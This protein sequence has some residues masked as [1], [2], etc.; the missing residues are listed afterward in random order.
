MWTFNNLSVTAETT[1]LRLGL[2]VD[3]VL[4]GQDEPSL[5]VVDGHESFFVLRPLHHQTLF[6]DVAVFH[7]VFGGHHRAPDIITPQYPM[8][9]TE[10]IGHDGPHVPVSGGRRIISKISAPPKSGGRTWSGPGR[11]F[12]FMLGFRTGKILSYSRVSAVGRPVD[13]CCLRVHRRGSGSACWRVAEQ[14]A[15][16]G[17]K[18]TDDKKFTDDGTVRHGCGGGVSRSNRGA[19]GVPYTTKRDFKNIKKKKRTR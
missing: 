19:K 11:Q 9:K 16:V 6:D 10:T 8:W 17:H 15:S 18:Q 4:G 2:V 5:L 7:V 13:V 14:T 12:W 1:Y 3:E